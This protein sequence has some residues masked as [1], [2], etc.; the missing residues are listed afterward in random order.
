MTSNY[1]YLIISQK[2]F[3]IKILIYFK[4]DM[5]HFSQILHNHSNQFFKNLI[6]IRFK[7]IKVNYFYVYQKN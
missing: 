1:Y 6:L 4:I 3:Y 5:F 7:G 2:E